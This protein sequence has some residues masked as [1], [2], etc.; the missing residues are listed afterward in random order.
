MSVPVRVRLR[1]IIFLEAHPMTTTTAPLARF[2]DHTNLRPDATEADIIKLCNEA[3]QYQ[4][5]SV[6]INPSNIPIA[7][8]N[9]K[10]TNVK[11]CTVIGFPLGANLT[12]TKIIEASQAI[13]AGATELDMV[14]N[15]GRA[16]QADWDYVTNEI[17]QIVNVAQ[18]A[19]VKVIIET[20]LLTDQEII[21]ASISAEKA[22]AHFVK[23]STGFNGPGATV[24]HIELIKK[25]ISPKIGIKASGGIKTKEQAIQL[26]N[27]GATRLGTSSGVL[28]V[29]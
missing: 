3:S 16:K 17:Q 29:T 25:S 11:V 6:C 28:L 14:I 1:A 22:G 18:N 4:F 27:A 20:S 7:Y 24:P 23:T 5:C 9:L 8:Q 19:T 10:N 12:S 2:I 26:I 15:I 13:E 21:Q